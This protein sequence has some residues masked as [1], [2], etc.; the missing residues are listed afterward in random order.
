M[1]DG[2]ILR[3]SLAADPRLVAGFT[4]RDFSPAEAGQD[5]AR[6]RLAEVTGLPVAS[7]GQVHGKAVA[8]V[9]GPGHVPAHDGLVTA[10]PGLVL[11]VVAADC[12]L[13]LLADAEAGV[14]GA[15][16]S[17]WRG[18]VAGV[19]G[20]TIAAM[21]ALGAA[22]ARMR[23]YLGPCISTEAFE[24]GE[25]VAAA[26]RDAVV[27]R[28]PEWP[29]PHVDL[30]AELGRQLAS[31]GVGDIETAGGCTVR[32]GD[33]FF[34]YRAENGTPGRMLGFVGLRTGG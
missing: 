19:L 16:H 30:K 9:D 21:A 28:R 6:A 3:P 34:S 17:G 20:E 32:D 5:A 22:P 15:C 2:S 27:A 1:T 4:T 24:V 7:A 29:R 10:T 31:A 33:R 12:A 18:T 13:V 23:A 11:S 25:E 14:V 8:V 26:F